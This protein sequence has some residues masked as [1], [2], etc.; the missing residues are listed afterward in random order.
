MPRTAKSEPPRMAVALNRIEFENY[1]ICIIGVFK[2]IGFIL[3]RM[4]K[5]RTATDGGGSK[6]K[7]CFKARQFIKL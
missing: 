1:H 5:L 2:L 3:P 4:A 7:R 6:Q